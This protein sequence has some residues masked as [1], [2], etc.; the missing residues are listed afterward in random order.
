MARYHELGRFSENAP[1]VEDGL[2]HLQK[3]A[4]AG[5]LEAVLTLAKIYLQLPCDQF[6]AFSVS[7][8]RDLQMACAMIHVLQLCIQTGVQSQDT[9]EHRDKGLALM[10]L[11]AVSG[12]R[13]ATVYM[14]KKCD[15]DG[16][17][18]WKEA[19]QWYHKAIEC[20]QDAGENNFVTN[21]QY[22]LLARV[23]EIHMT[24]GGD[25]DQDPQRAGNS[26]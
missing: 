26:D 21:S 4:Q 6:C 8:S 20:E 1:N 9:D 23:A 12:C 7:V 24:G 10:R 25:M 18:S 19:V 14:A 17:D 3:A 15:G 5:M 22:S 13:D 2:F 11:A 16:P